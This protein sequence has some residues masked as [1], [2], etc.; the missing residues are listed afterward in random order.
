[1]PDNLVETA[2]ELASVT[3]PERQELETPVRPKSSSGV[4]PRRCPFLSHTPVLNVAVGTKN[5][6][7]LGAVRKALLRT[8]PRCSFCHVVSQKTLTEARANNAKG[9]S[10]RK[11]AQF[12]LMAQEI[13]EHVDL[14]CEDHISSQSGGNDQ[15]KRVSALDRVWKETLAG[16]YLR[17][18][19]DVLVPAVHELAAAT[20]FDADKARQQVRG[21]LVR[22]FQERIAH[23]GKLSDPVSERVRAALADELDATQAE[24]DV[25]SF[26]AR[27]PGYQRFCEFTDPTRM[28]GGRM[29]P[30]IG[31]RIFGVG[32]ISSGV[33]EQPMS[34]QECFKG[35]QNRA[36]LAIAGGVQLAQD[37]GLSKQSTKLFDVW[38]P[39]TIH[40]GIGI[41][42]GISE[43]P[44]VTSTSG[45]AGGCAYSAD[46]TLPSTW[47]EAG[48]V[49]ALD[50]RGGARSP[51]QSGPAGRFG[52]GTSAGFEVHGEVL[53]RMLKAKAEAA[54]G[55]GFVQGADPTVDEEA[56]SAAK[57]S[58][59]VTMGT[60]MGDIAADPR[61]GEKGGM[62]GIL[63]DQLVP[64]GPCYEDAILFALGPLGLSPD[65]RLRFPGT[66]S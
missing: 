4:E 38:D 42:G 40:L 3:P 56:D 24:D 37:L 65:A 6:A 17:T 31:I 18:E 39:P 50:P 59:P 54:I 16:E 29:N 28:S 58:E 51:G 43:L 36:H 1:M 20:D 22:H 44:G 27:F 7:K 30:H 26:K 66:G 55:G 60:V 33:S 41:E 21:R 15:S 5:P 14:V 49:A 25:L 53:A 57:P 10:G 8:F 2:G 11:A 32:G 12:G 47:I 63:T 64:R 13:G 34:A 61:I 23:L 46:H 48:Y 19:Q 62:M 52:L 9:E 45:A 35:A